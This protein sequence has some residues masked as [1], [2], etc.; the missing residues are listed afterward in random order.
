MEQDRRKFPRLQCRLPVRL[1]PKQEPR[2]IETLTKDLSL[3]GLRCVSRHERAAGMPLSVELLLE[4]GER[5]MNIRGHVTWSRPIQ[6]SEQFDIGVAFSAFPDMSK[7]R[8]STYLDRLTA[9]S[10]VPASASA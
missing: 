2:V 7:K 4:S 6:D 10:A 3:G 9:L 8:L 5:P 1:Y